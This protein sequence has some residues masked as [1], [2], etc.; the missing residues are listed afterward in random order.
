MSAQPWQERRREYLAAK[1]KARGAKVLVMPARSRTARVT[2]AEILAGCRTTIEFLAGDSRERRPGRQ[3]GGGERVIGRGS[4]I[5][6]DDV[7]APDTQHLAGGA[8]V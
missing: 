4:A 1:G 7:V 5:H 2:A 6:S 8:N 3:K